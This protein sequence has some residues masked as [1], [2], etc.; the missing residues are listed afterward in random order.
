LPITN[1]PRPGGPREADSPHPAA[2]L[3]E[4]VRLYG[5]RHWIEMVFTQLAKRAVRPVRG[6][7]ST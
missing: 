4:I 5:I 7:G 6:I 2:D 3:A 1:L